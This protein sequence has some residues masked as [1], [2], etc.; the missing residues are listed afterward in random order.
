MTIHPNLTLISFKKLTVFSFST[1]APMFSEEPTFTLLLFQPST[2]L[3]R[4]TSPVVWCAIHPN[5]LA[6]THHS[7]ERE[8]WGEDWVKRE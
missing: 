1:M 3:P 7:L 5:P 4:E 8:V 6:D 2:V